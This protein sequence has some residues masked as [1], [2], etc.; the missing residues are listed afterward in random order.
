MSARDAILAKVRAS[1]GRE[2]GDG[3][4][5][6]PGPA[7]VVKVGE[8]IESFVRF[9]EGVSAS[10]AR[11]ADLDAL[12]GAIAA[13]LAAHN[14]PARLVATADADFDAVPWDAN[15]ALEVARGVPGKEDLVALSQAAAG[16]AETGS[17]VMIGD[18]AN[19]HMAS[20][21][22]ETAIVL[23]RAGRIVG[24]LEDAFAG[25][26]SALPRAVCLVTGPSRTGDIGLQ[27]ELGAHGPR[28]VHIIIVDGPP[29]P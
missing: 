5:A 28:R 19:P 8:H 17:L 7:P 21:V 23:L 27:I 1:L 2:A 29:A 12:P 15:P 20:F 24:G 22:P 4:A 6:R 11:I 14:L 25:L 3:V 9:A 10:V 13:Y 18:A 16:I 26:P